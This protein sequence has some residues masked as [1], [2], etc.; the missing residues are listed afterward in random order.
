MH[1]LLSPAPRLDALVAA[2]CLAAACTGAAHALPLAPTVTREINFVSTRSMCTGLLPLGGDNMSC[3]LTNGA[4]LTASFADPYGSPSSGNAQLFADGVDMSL[5]ATTTRSTAPTSIFD[6]VQFDQ[7]TITGPTA[8]VNVGV[9]VTI[10]G[11]TARN[12][13]GFVLTSYTFI[14]GNRS[15]TPSA[16]ANST[17]DR[18][19]NDPTRDVLAFGRTATLGGGITQSI[20]HRVD[21]ASFTGVVGAPF[22]HG[23]EFV[24]S[25]L[26]TTMSFSARVEYSLPAGYT[27]TSLRGLHVNV[28]PENGSWALMLAG[29]AGLA[30]L[31]LLRRSREGQPARPA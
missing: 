1:N 7:F 11:A 14:S 8:T 16:S 10:D 18:I 31:R 20:L 4:Q 28:V 2:A 24:L 19:S 27:L 5:S 12:S 26:N 17:G 30:G 9:K 13:G 22:E 29:L 25:S 6:A 23:F 21:T 15:A 3:T